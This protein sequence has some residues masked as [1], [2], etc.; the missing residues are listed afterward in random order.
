MS[1][2]R[3]IAVAVFLA[4]FQGLFAS[5]H[6]RGQADPVEWTQAQAPFRVFGNTYYV[7]T[8]GLSS[9]L[10]TSD[11]G[12][13][14]IDGAMPQSAQMIADNIRTLGFRVE[15]VKLIVNSHIHYDH[16]GG[17]GG[18]QRLTGARVAAS[19]SSA[20]VLKSGRA[21]PDDPQYGL[22]RPIDTV[23]NV[24]VI[25]DGDILRVGSLSIQGHFTGGHTRGGTSWTWRSC[26]GTECLNIV[27][28]DSMTAV[29]ADGFKYGSN[30]TYPQA[31]ADFE[32]SIAFL[33]K[34]PCDLLLTPHPDATGLWGRLAKRD[35][36]DKNGLIE[37]GHC[38]RYAN[39]VE[40]GLRTRLAK[41]KS[42]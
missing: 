36:G 42:P 14:L 15:D 40:T 28:A 24:Q 12:H 16:A 35:A 27:Y 25:A 22:T 18:L 34:T 5:V 2:V 32:K 10:I 19:P 29:S 4:V 13:V 7:G 39:R 20:A 11:T 17:I 21:G 8:R 23:A 31:V 1:S 26:E 41:E 38:A 37:R 6:L 9:I 30:T 3:V 33:R